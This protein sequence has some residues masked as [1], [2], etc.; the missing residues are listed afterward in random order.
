MS[1]P[2]SNMGKLTAD[3]QRIVPKRKVDIAPMYNHLELMVVN[4]QALMGIM[5]PLT[6]KKPVV[7]HC[8]VEVDTSKAFIKVG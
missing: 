2:M 3:Q 7:N 5:I 4:N 8:T 6:N 1:R